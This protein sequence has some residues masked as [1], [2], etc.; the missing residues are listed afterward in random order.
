MLPQKAGQ[1]TAVA[2][3]SRHKIAYLTKEDGTAHWVEAKMT[4]FFPTRIK[5]LFPKLPKK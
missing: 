2:E 3:N 1:E 4:L 5:R